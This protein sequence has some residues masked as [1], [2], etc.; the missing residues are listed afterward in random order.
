MEAA[1][2]KAK[3]CVGSAEHHNIERAIA[4]KAVTLLKNDGSLPV[5][6]KDVSVVVLGRTERDVTPIDYALSELMEL[7]KIDPNARVE[8]AIT[9]KVTGPENASARIYI[10]RYYDLDKKELSWAD[11]LSD[12][13]SKAQYVVCLCATGAGLDA[14]QD[15]DGRMQGVTRA[16]KEAHAAGAKFVLLSDNI[17]V[18]AARFTDADAIV[19][20]YL[21]AGFDI[22]PSKK[23]ESGNMRAINAN[24]PAAL[25]AIFG[26]AN[27]PGALPIN[28]NALEKDKDGTWAYTDKV[29]YARGTKAG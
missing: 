14:L 4:E 17:P 25:R 13:I 6:G 16:L 11:G 22:D 2:A 8:N 10:N 26:A 12:A 20:C 5:P 3:D 9:G 23:N 21:S 24:V 27:M 19:C 1:I 29:L 15:K 18:D 7:G 28:I